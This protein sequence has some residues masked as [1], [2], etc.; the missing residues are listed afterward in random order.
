MGR[1]LVLTVGGLAGVGVEGAGEASIEGVGRGVVLD[2]TSW[3][4]STSGIC[5]S[6]FVLGCGAGSV[7]VGLASFL[8]FFGFGAG[9]RACSEAEAEAEASSDRR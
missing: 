2:G 6:V 3:R 4:G 9:L 8:P 7:G 5:V 1:V